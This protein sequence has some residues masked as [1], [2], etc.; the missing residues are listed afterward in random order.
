MAAQLPRLGVDGLRQLP[1]RMHRQV[2]EQDEVKVS[3]YLKTIVYPGLIAMP[4]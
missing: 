2:S 1:I 3:A 4:P